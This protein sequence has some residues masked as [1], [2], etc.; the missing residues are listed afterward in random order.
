MLR[1]DALVEVEDPQIRHLGG[2]LDPPP[3]TFLRYL[4]PNGWRLANGEAVEVV[5][6]VR[7][8]EEVHLACRVEG[9][10]TAAQ[11]AV[12]WTGRL[13]PP[14][15][16]TLPASGDIRLPPPPASDR[17]TLRLALQAPPETT[18]V[19]DRITLGWTR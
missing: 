4:V 15:M 12:S 18:A 17:L 14:V 16:V 6:P 1:Q 8:G 11:L 2:V 19:L 7:A 13:G 10:G 3:G 5:I 9:P